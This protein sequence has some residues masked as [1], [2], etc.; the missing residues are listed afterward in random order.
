MI[1]LKAGKRLR[2]VTLMA[3]VV[4]CILLSACG[5]DKKAASSEESNGT[6][7]ISS[8]SAGDNSEDHL[9]DP[10]ERLSGRFYI[11]GDSSAASVVVK[12]DGSFTAYYASGTVE[13]EG[14]VKYE[15]DANNPKF[16]VYVFYT[17]EGKPYMGFVDSGENKISAFE[18][19]NGSYR[20]VR[21][22]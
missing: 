20:Y 3:A 14:Y 17:D 4:L 5:S 1:V 12:S 9:A 7:D 8:K 19:G 22:D 2:F 13:R 11:D 21:V 6:P 10:M 18:T 15:A 16:Y